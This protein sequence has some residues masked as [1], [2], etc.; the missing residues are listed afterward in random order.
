MLKVRMYEFA[1]D[2][3]GGGIKGDA[4]D[5]IKGFFGDLGAALVSMAVHEGHH[6]GQ[7]GLLIGIVG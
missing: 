7:I 1:H 3:L 5:D 6:G 2:E 4:S